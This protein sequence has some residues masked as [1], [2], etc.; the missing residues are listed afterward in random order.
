MF[1]LFNNNDITSNMTLI[2]E[3]NSHI[4][5]KLKNFNIYI[6]NFLTCK[7]LNSLA[8]NSIKIWNELPN[9]IKSEKRFK[10]FNRLLYDYLLNAYEI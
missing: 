7:S 5:R 1:K 9:N 8:V 6:S 2:N 3:I 4:T 10:L